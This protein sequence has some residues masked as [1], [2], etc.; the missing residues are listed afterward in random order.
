MNVDS[1]QFIGLRLNFWPSASTMNMLSRVVV[2]VARLAPQPLGDHDRGAD[3]LVAAPLLELA[4]GGL[5]ASARSAA[6]SDARRPSPGETSWKLNRSSCDAQLAVVA[7]LRLLA[8]PQVPVELLLRLPDRAVDP[9]E[10]RALLVAA[11]VGA[12]DGEQLERADLPGG[13]DVRA[14]AQVAER[15]VLVEGDRRHRLAGLGR[16]AREVV[17]DLDL[18]RLAVA[19]LDRPALGERDLAADE[20]VV[21]GDARRASGPRSPTRSSG[22]QRSRQLEVVVEAVVDRGPDAQPRAREQVQHGLG[23]DVRRAVAHGVDRRMGAGVEQLVRRA[24][25]GRLER[26]L[27]LVRGHRR[28]RLVLSHS[29]RSRETQ[30]LSSRQDERF[31]LPRFHPPSRRRVAVSCARAALTGGSRA[32]SPAARGWCRHRS[33]LSGLAADGPGSLAT[34][35]WGVSRSTRSVLRPGGRRW[36]AI[37]DS[38]Q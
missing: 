6:P 9:L 24:A 27:V 3:L 1:G 38:N 25:I 7:L 4:H 11:P 30:N 2:P 32:G 34:S 14:L 31:D 5:A 26:D 33:G 10:H 16:L 22:R 35:R 12:G 15:A 20:G 37:L 8:P 29:L 13:L 23:H 19:L 36:W 28:G 18:E 21:R 17:E